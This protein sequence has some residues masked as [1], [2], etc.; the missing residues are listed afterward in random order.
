[1]APECIPRRF[2]SILYAAGKRRADA[3]RYL[4]TIEAP[5]LRLF[6]QIELAAALGGLPEFG[7]IQREYRPRSFRARH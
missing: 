2:R 1:M 5:D 7:G 4:P 3:A 6:A